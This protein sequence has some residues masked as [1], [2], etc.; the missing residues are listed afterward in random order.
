MAPCPTQIAVS[1]PELDGRLNTT[2]PLAPADRLAAIDIL[3][4]IALFGVMA[5]NVVF[6]FRVSIFLEFLSPDRT[7]SP[8]DQMVARV[9][10]QAVELKAFA[11]FSLLFGVG[12]AIQ[13]DRLPAGRRAALLLRRL[14]VLLAIGL[15]HLTLIWN[16]DILTEYALAG[17]VVLPF[18]FGPRWL[19]GVGSLAFL[20]L[21]LSDYLFRLVPLY[22]KAWIGR[23]VVEAAHVY[24]AGGFAEI[25]SFRLDE[26]SAI[27][28]LHVWVFP[29][30][31]ALFLIGAF[32]WRTGVL[33]R[34][35]E[36]RSLIFGAGFVSLVVTIGAGQSLASVTLA[37]AYACFIIA[38][39]ST[40]LGP[41]LLGWAAPLGRMAFTNYLM[42]SLIFGWVF[43]GYG[44]GLFG[45]LGAATA[46]MI[47][48]A[49]YVAQVIISRWWLARFNFGPVEWL[50]RTLMYGQKQPMRP[51]AP[52]GVAPLAAE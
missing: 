30:T 12:L 16:G 10:D 18:L 47:G 39:A 11:L 38:A 29:R 44:L 15:V 28:P 22:D 3:R 23:H 20:S 52:A 21:Y 48:V 4:G 24:G 46:L 26:I 36:H 51:K 2:E 41:N 42:Q 43:Y 9:L 34:A 27:A 31:L 25:L 35:S 40:Q 17:F 50:W 45:K 37:L 32:V 14:A 19:V 1:D 33:Q 49:V 13:F 6:E 8:I 5:I 7:A